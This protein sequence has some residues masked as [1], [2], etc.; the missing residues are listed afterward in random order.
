MS[1]ADQNKAKQL[2]QSSMQENKTNMTEANRN[3]LGIQDEARGTARDILPT[4]TGTY[5][6]IASTGGYDQ[7]ILPSIQNLYGSYMSTGGISDEEAGTMRRRA[8]ESVSSSFQAA[9]DQA[10]RESAATGGY[11]AS[12]GAVLGS[13]ARQGAEAAARST[14]D[15]DAGIAALRQQGKLAGASGQS[16]LQQNLVSNRLQAASGASNI[17]GMSENQVSMTVD[18][19]LRNYQQTGQL[20]NQDLAILTNLANQP[21]V[22]DKIVSTIGTIGGAAAGVIGAV[23][24]GGLIK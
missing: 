20:N 12:S 19:I 24:P 18:Q 16:Q 17:Y 13:L 1:K 11:G 6:D 21:G 3:I 8:G 7:N 22:F 9:Q 15:V 23:A 10:R 5:K 4:A 14:T 2:A